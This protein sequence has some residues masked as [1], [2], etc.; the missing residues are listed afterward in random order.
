MYIQ[1]LMYIPYSWIARCFFLDLSKTFDN[2]WHEDLFLNF[3]Q[4]SDIRMVTIKSMCTQGLILGPLYINDLLGDIEWIVKLCP[5]DTSWVSTVHD[6]KILDNELNK[7][8]KKY[9]NRHI[10]GKCH[11][12]RSW[13]SRLNQKHSGIYL[14]T[15]L[16][17][18]H[19]ID[20]KW[21]K[22]WAELVLLKTKLNTSRH[23]HCLNILIMGRY[24]MI[25]E[26]MKI[27]AQKY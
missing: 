4:R 20:E 22:K 17:L 18:D 11:L 16:N 8:F 1:P 15:N 12:T 9:L 10:N 19:L 21:P 26:S 25:N 27:Y 3:N 6:I 2:F 7:D 24:F 5:C 14:G 23:L 13:T